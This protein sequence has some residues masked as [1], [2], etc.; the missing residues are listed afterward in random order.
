MVFCY[1]SLSIRHIIRLLRIGKLFPGQEMQGLSLKSWKVRNKKEKRVRRH[2]LC[3]S[4]DINTTCSIIQTTDLLFQSLHSYY[5]SII[6]SYS[7]ILSPA[8][9]F[10]QS[11]A[12]ICGDRDNRS[13]SRSRS[14]CYM[15]LGTSQ[16]DVVMHFPI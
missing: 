4:L 15:S 6:F 11:P 7:R 16:C 14:Y 12:Q 5:N 9:L 8:Y 10:G 3:M 2:I 13:T 1:L